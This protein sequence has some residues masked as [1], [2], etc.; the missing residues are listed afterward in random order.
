MF[1]TVAI[2]FDLQQAISLHQSGHLQQAEIIYQRIL[3]VDL[4][5]ADALNLLGLVSHQSGKSTAAVTLVKRALEISSNQ[6]TDLFS[7]LIGVGNSSE[8]VGVK[9]WKKS[10]MECLNGRKT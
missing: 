2:R 3:D 8:N 6:P 1:D 10:P 9:S 4:E 5:N 7:H